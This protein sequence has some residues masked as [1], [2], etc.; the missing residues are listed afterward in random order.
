MS[1]KITR[2][3]GAVISAEGLEDPKMNNIVNVGEKKLIGEIVK[4]IG[5][6]AI[7]Q[8]YEEVSGL[9][10]GEPVEDTGS[11]LSVEL[12]PGLI[13]SIFDGIQRPL[14]KLLQKSGDFIQSGINAEPLDRK[15]KWHFLAKVKQGAQL[16]EGQEIG[17]VQETS[18]VKHKIL[19]PP[20]ISGKVLNV[21]SG[22]FTLDDTIAVV[23]NNGKKTEIKMVQKWPVR[24]ARPVKEKL[25]PV[26]PLITG[27][28]VID[29]FFPVAKGGTASIPGPFGSGKTVVSHQLARWSDADIIVYVGAGERGN[30]MTEILTSF[31]D[32][33]DPKTGEPL[34]DRTILIANTSNMPVTGREAS[35]YTGVTIAEYFRDMGY[36]VAL[37][38][39]STSRWAEAL[40]EISQRLEE[41]PGEEGY[42]AYLSKRISEFYE[43]A[44]RCRLLNGKIGSITLIG[45]VSPP[46][47]DISEP[48]SQNTLRATRVF[49]ALDASLA[50]SRHFP[51]INWLNSYSLYLEQ[52]DGWYR[53]NIADDWPGLRD[54]MIALLQREAEI[55]EIVQLVGYDAISEKDKLVLD[56]AKAIREAF[57]QQNAFDEV[58]TFSSI[59]KQYLMLKAIQRLN[60]VESSLVEGGATVEQLQSTDVKQR[61]FRFKFVKEEEVESYSKELMKLI[62]GLSKSK[63]KEGART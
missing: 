59:K 6:Q 22:D 23:E 40:R 17:E 18:L 24:Q 48:V 32:L 47:G 9:R 36:S 38:A 35:I 31:P 13:G 42:P 34:M 50:N 27:Q 33:K 15:K 3:S 8:V 62:D 29:T 1:G 60:D 2:I 14:D 49:W 20:G 10:V 4:I 11:R 25:P 52:L 26:I 12:G 7:I 54:G 44:G 30:E 57:L 56:I 61:L 63:P 21:K 51:A 41:M 16:E 45:A 19:V 55:N 37:M 58:D 5:D 43:M 39:D 28:R 53:E 46:G